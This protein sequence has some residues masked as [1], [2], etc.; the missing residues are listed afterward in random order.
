MNVDRFSLTYK[1][2]IRIEF[3]AGII[4]FGKVVVLSTSPPEKRTFI[5]LKNNIIPEKI[6]LN[7]NAIVTKNFN[8]PINPF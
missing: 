8:A 5:S 7:L 2:Q 1:N 6:D 3:I 4:D